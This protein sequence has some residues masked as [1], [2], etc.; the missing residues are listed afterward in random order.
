MV[1]TDEY[2]AKLLKKRARS[3]AVSWRVA[4]MASDLPYKGLFTFNRSIASKAVRHYSKDLD[5]L[6]NRYNIPHLV[7]APKVAGLMASAVLKYRPLVPTNC[8][9]GDIEDNEVNEYLAIWHGIIVCAN[10]K[11]DGKYA[12]GDLARKPFFDEWLKRFV[13]LLRERNYTSES[14]VMVFETLC[15][16]A[17]PEAIESK[18]LHI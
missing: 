6:R 2:R 12:M 15:F 17:F 8:K 3:L 5:V 1:L 7:Q 4:S 9:Q 10:F 18:T 11:D 13:Y 14:L 16:A